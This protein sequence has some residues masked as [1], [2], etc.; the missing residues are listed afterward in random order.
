MSHEEIAYERN[1]L[2]AV[3]LK[4]DFGMENTVEPT[5]ELISRL[6]SSFPKYQTVEEQLKQADFQTNSIM[7][8]LK[9]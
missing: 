9:Q 5:A 6:R 7:T 2:Q 8:R 4:I 3:I 1:Q